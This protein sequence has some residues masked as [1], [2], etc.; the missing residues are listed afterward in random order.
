MTIA[1]HEI[2]T[3]SY[4]LYLA[5]VFCLWLAFTFVRAPFPVQVLL[6]IAALFLVPFAAYHVIEA[7]GIRLGV[8]VARGSRAAVEVPVAAASASA[9]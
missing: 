7:P 2:A 9:P 1:A 4:G 5:H 8:R 6:W 3:Y